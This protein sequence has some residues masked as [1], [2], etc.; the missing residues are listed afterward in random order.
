MDEMTSFEM[1]DEIWRKLAAARIL[2]YAMLLCRVSLPADVAFNYTL[3]GT[4][5]PRTPSEEYYK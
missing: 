2:I 5:V 1:A 4:G 3:N